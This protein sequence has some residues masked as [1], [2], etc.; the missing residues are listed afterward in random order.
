MQIFFVLFQILTTSSFVICLAL[1]S[2]EE[3]HL[4]RGHITDAYYFR[5]CFRSDNL[6]RHL[7]SL[8]RRGSLARIVIDEAHCVSQWGHDFRP[9]Y[10]VA[11]GRPF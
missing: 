7:E 10:Q 8:H 5:F 3:M 1:P 11:C 2:N 4:K 6:C 9:D